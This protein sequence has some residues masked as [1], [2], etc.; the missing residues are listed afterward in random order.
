MSK[1]DLESVRA[2]VRREFSLLGWQNQLI[3]ESI[4]LHQSNYFGHRFTC[5]RW[6]AVWELD[7]DQITIFVEKQQIRTALIK[8]ND[9]NEEFGKAA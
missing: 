6:C 2:A 8:T 9:G 4:L 3:E 7:A 5:K 1:F